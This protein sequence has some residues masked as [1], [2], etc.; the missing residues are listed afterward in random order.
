MGSARDEHVTVVTVASDVVAVVVN[1]VA[2]M[3]GTAPNAPI[4]GSLRAI[5][6]AASTAPSAAYAVER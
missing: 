5:W 4:D 3:H 6:I 1:A 2:C